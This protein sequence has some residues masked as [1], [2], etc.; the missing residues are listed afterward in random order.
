MKDL[1]HR[2]GSRIRRHHRRRILPAVMHRDQG[3]DALAEI[4][5]W[6][7]DDDDDDDFKVVH[8]ET[9]KRQQEGNS[10]R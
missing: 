10:A 2:A 6:D 1:R 3:K 4:G 5:G 7:D 9:R 8:T